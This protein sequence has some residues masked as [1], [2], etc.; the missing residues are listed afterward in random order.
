MVFLRYFAD[1]SYA[2]IAEAC[3]VSEGTVSAALAQA[4]AALAQ[5]LDTEEASR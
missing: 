5:A 1:L 2:D 3:D 4:R